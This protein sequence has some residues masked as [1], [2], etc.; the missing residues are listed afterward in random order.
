[1]VSVVQV[2]I[3]AICMLLLNSSYTVLLTG[4]KMHPDALI[5]YATSKFRFQGLMKVKCSITDIKI[6]KILCIYGEI[7]YFL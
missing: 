4:S 1:M 3:S 5:F 6:I 2:L 7:P